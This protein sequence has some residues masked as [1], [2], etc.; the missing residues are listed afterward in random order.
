MDVRSWGI[1]FHPDLLRGTS[2]SQ[3]MKE[4]SFFSYDSNEALHLSN[5]EKKILTEIV[6]KIEFRAF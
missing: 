5:K 6:S 1:F 4:Y 3:K 2:L